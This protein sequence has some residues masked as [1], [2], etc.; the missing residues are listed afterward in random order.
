[1]ASQSQSLQDLRDFV[2]LAIDTDETDL[3][4]GILDRFL[5][6]G[7][8]RVENFSDSWS[9]RAVTYTFNT[10]VGVQSYD[11]TTNLV[12][13]IDAPLRRI[14]DLQGPNLILKPH[15][16]AK[17][18]KAYVGTVANQGTPYAYSKWGD[19]IYLWPTPSVAQAMSITGYRYQSD[20]VSTGAAPDF[21]NDLTELI[22]WWG[23]SRAHARE[24]DPGMAAFYAGEFAVELKNRSGPYLGG[25]DAAPFSMN[26]DALDADDNDWRTSRFGG[27]RYDWE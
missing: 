16:H 5:I 25:L 13:G 18:R 1:M 24:G 7:A 17:M 4:N 21:P 27:P 10:E 22:E 9:F 14:T 26:Q 20:W 8:N 15:P 19:K 12:A 11:V 6:D 2:R 23:L 3:P